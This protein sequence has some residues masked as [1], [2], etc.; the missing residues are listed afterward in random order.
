MVPAHTLS[1]VNDNL[2]TLGAVALGGGIATLTQFTSDWV[3]ERRASRSRWYDQRHA[4]YGRFLAEMLPAMRW[5]EQTGEL[6]RD[7]A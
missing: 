6:I 7:G 4:A 3:R 1:A 5:L 2:V